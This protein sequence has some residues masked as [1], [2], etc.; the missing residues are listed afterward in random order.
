MNHILSDPQAHAARA[1]PPHRD[2]QVGASQDSRASTGVQ[3][4]V[5]AAQNWPGWPFAEL[6]LLKVPLEP[7][8]RV[9]CEFSARSAPLWLDSVA[10]GPIIATSSA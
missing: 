8:N 9:L 3:A 2:L 6:S 10:S 7:S 4:H 5:T 1:G